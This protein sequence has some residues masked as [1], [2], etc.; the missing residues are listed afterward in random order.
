MAEKDTDQVIEVAG[1]KLNI[2]PVADSGDDGPSGVESHD[3]SN[4]DSF[5]DKLVGDD[6]K[7]KTV[8]ELAKG[9]AHAQ[10]HIRKLEEENASLREKHEAK[11]ASEEMVNEVL[12]R[13]DALSGKPKN[14]PDPDDHGDPDDDD[15]AQN[16][17]AGKIE[18]LV[19]QS[20]ENVLTSR[21]E[22][23]KA[24]KIK[25]Q[26]EQNQKAAWDAL[27]NQYEGDMEKAK[28]AVLEY[29]GESQA[30]AKVLDTLSSDDPSEFVKIVS[31]AKAD[32]TFFADPS[33]RR[34]PPRNDESS[35]LTWEKARQ[36]KKEN[37]DLYHS[38]EFQKQL[39]QARDR[40]PNFWKGTKRFN[41]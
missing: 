6:K 37:P 17:D 24:E 16:L 14:D 19:K 38:K 27:A 40:N 21:E 20:V 30:K 11:N 23:T 31:G 4:Q 41:K 7:Y 2:S 12:A 34:Q 39:V 33:K 13:L 36:I 9:T 26:Q 28:A 32:P 8:D 5:I 22:Q 15:T 1:Q 3:D 10:E 25:A 18:E 29:V 35:G